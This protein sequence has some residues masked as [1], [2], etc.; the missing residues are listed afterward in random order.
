MR[1]YLLGTP[2]IWWL[3]LAVLVLWP[4]LWVVLHLVHIHYGKKT[5]E[6][7]VMVKSELTKLS[8]Q[9]DSAKWFYLFWAVHYFPFFLMGR[10]LYF[11]HYFPAFIFSCLVTGVTLD[12]LLQIT[13]HSLHFYNHEKLPRSKSTVNLK[14]VFVLSAAILHNFALYSPLSY[15]MTGPF[16]SNATS[17]MHGLKLLETWDF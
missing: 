14:C 1:I 8:K 11:H 17:S 4:V 7:T 16:A 5:S 15:G 9:C 6:Q 10:I 3:N 13:S 12:V 2:L